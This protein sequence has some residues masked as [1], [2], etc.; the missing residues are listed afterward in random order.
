MTRLQENITFLVRQNSSLSGLLNDDPCISQLEAFCEIA[1]VSLENLLQYNLSATNLPWDQ[2]KFIF[3]DVD[4]VM[5]EGG[6]FYTEE[7]SEF[8]RF[9]TKDGMAIKEAMKHGI[10]FGII[11]SGVNKAIIQ[12]RADMFGIKHVYVGAEP[13]MSI[14]ET[15]LADMALDWDQIGYIGDDIN[16]LKMFDKVEIAACP[17]DATNP[18]K[19]AASFV[20]EAKGGHGCVREFLRYLPALKS[21]L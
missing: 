19:A 11:S 17:A 10:E 21:I 8:K 2:I 3:L 13:K 20:L 1:E 4:G 18:I 16:D 14:A 9:D 5:T 7:G 12:H 6:M 15:W